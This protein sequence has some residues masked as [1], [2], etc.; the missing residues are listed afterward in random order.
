MAYDK[1]TGIKGVDKLRE[2][3]QKILDLAF[4]GKQNSEIAQLL[5][6]HPRSV[7]LI[8]NSPIFQGELARRGALRQ[9]EVQERVVEQQVAIELGVAT[10]LE[11][12]ALEAAEV[13]IQLLRS[14]NENTRSK[15]AMDILD[16]AG[17]GAQK[18]LN[19]RKQSVVVQVNLE[20]LDRILAAATESGASEQVEN[21]ILGVGGMGQ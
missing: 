15:S 12:A 16:R 18:T 1:G 19:V 9:N 17:Y 14:D 7:S 3:H 13:Q 2:R 8:R 21:G 10:R 11:R 4:E 6:I 5:G 20:D